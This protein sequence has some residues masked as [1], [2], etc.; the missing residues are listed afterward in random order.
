VLDGSSD[1]HEMR[2][3]PQKR[4][5]CREVQIELYPSLPMASLQRVHTPTGIRADALAAKETERLK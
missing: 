3:G 2:R 5:L 1:V 4:R